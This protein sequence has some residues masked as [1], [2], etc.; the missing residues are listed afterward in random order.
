MSEFIEK[1]FIY[2]A[3]GMMAIYVIFWRIIPFVRR[4]RQA[5]RSLLSRIYLNQQANL[6]PE[7]YQ[8]LSTGAIYSEQQAAYINS[9]T[10]G[11][12][13]DRVQEILAGW[14]HLHNAQ[15]A[16][17]KL[18]YLLHKGFRFYFDKVM[19]AYGT[20]SLEQQEQIIIN[21][22]DRADATYAEDTQKAYSQL[23]NLKETWEELITNDIIKNR[24][25]LDH[26]RNVGWDCGRLSFVSR[27]CYD[28]QYIT[29]AEAWEYINQAHQLAVDN[30][31]SWQG[32]AK[33]YVIG[34]AMWGGTNNANEDVIA[35]AEYLLREPNSP[36]V[37]FSLK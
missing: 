28:A 1:Y 22:F 8:R 4:L 13:S 20:P 16:K 5:S 6:T 27:L 15:Q 32:Y 18:D 17:D 24:A 31:D 11:L 21:G 33:S 34:R 3:I 2:Y 29:E 14:W 26:Y 12:S 37:Q 7:Q 9:L 35:I 30:F 25:D 10:T 23:S 19:E 36:W